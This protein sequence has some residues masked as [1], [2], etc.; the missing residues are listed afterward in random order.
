MKWSKEADQAVSRVP[1]FVRKR[2]RK[3]VEEEAE[4]TGSRMVTLDHVQNS[5]KRFLSEMDQEV[6]GFQVETCFGPSGCPNRAVEGEGIAQELEQGL[7]KRDLKTFLKEKVQGPLKIHHEFR[8]SISC[9]PNACSRPQ[10]VDFG[11]IGVSRPKI[12]DEPCSQ[13]RACIDVCKEEAVNLEESAESPLI[14][15]D[16]CL[17][18][19]QCISVC[20]TGTLQEVSQGFRV[21]VGGKLGRHPQLGKDLGK[22][23]SKEEMLQVLNQYLDL[24]QSRNQRGERLGEILKRLED[25]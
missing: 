23:Y 14:D 20:P 7:L 9:C 21:L 2:V 1:F 10:I 17:S 6:K 16:K 19:G 8:V 15:F 18:C 5:Q 11:I 22:I 3:K 4:R 25:Q 13:C 12:T 24:Y